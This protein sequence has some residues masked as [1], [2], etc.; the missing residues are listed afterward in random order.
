MP[1]RLQ[2][3]RRPR[4]DLG[5]PLQPLQLSTTRNTPGAPGPSS[6]RTYSSSL[7][8]CRRILCTISIGHASAFSLASQSLKEECQGYLYRY[9]HVS[10]DAASKTSCSMAFQLL[11]I[12]LV[13]D[14]HT[15][16]N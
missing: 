4:L 1:D 11:L 10:F 5:V 6:R 8:Q 7:V 15:V 13:D 9:I 2:S 12:L 3:R 14:H 16:I